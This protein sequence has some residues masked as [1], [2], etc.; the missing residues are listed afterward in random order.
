M[1]ES[2][3]TDNVYG[4]GKEPIKVEDIVLQQYHQPFTDKY[5]LR[6]KEILEAEGLN[7][8]VRFQVFCRKACHL[9][10]MTV[11]T[12]ILEHYGEV[13]KNGGNIYALKDGAGIEPNETVMTVEARIQDVIELETMYLGILSMK[14]SMS[15]A[16]GAI[17]LDECYTNMKAVVD[18]VGDRDV[19]YAGARHWDY[20]ADAHICK[21]AAAAGAKGC[22]TDFGALMGWRKAGGGMGT[23]PHALENIFAWKYGMDKA[24]VE[25]TKAFD[26]HIKDPLVDTIALVDFNNKEVDD[27]IAVV[28]ELGENIKGIRIDTCGENVMQGAT[29][30]MN[31]KEKDEKPYIHG[32]GVSVE[33][34]KAV[35]DALKGIGREDVKI[36]LSSGFANVDK[37]KAFLEAEKEH[38]KLFDSLL[39]GG[40]Y[41]SISFTMDIVAVGDTLD[42][43]KPCSKVGRVYKANDK[44]EKITDE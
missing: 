5:F 44:L 31:D 16:M 37:V 24:V 9:D 18:L 15:N 2:G 42:D 29:P 4:E 27:T 14:T 39:V 26:K 10:G 7:P 8:W 28:K 34:V 12:K 43:M 35:R 6:S 33:G 36:I 40:I 17:N 25:S 13:S 20:M 41:P 38:G 1:S 21:A 22:S 19:F 23:I 3:K 32:N 30:Y 11:A